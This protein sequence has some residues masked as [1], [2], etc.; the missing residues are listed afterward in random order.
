MAASHERVLE[1][2]INT[3]G[4]KGEAV[5]LAISGRAGLDNLLSFRSE[6][7]SALSHLSPASLKVDLSGLEYID[8]AAALALVD[9]SRKAAAASIPCEFVNASQK[10]QGVMGLIDPETIAQPPLRQEEGPPNFFTR[11]GRMYSRNCF[12]RLR[13][14]CVFGRTFVGSGLLFPTSRVAEADGCFLLHET[15]RT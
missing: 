9:L 5:K 1:F 15:G 2:N 3:K 11:I 6:L 12:G 10:T 7:E 4:Q 13:P 14:Q 8:S